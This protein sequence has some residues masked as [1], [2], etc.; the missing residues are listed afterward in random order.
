MSRYDLIVCTTAV[1]RTCLH[2]VVF[3]SYFSFLKG[4]K[5][6]WLINLDRVFNTSIKE[7]MG[8]IKEGA[9]IHC[10]EMEIEFF[11]E[12]EKLTGTR[13]SFFKAAENLILKAG[14]LNPK[15]GIL[16]LEDDWA[17]N[18]NITGKRLIDILQDIEFD[19]NDYLQLVERSRE[20][21]FNP[22]VFG[23]RLFKD[24]CIKGIQNNTSKYFLFNPERACCYPHIEVTRSVNKHT[25][26]PLFYDIGRQWQEDIAVNRTFTVLETEDRINER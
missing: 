18:P 16:W 22:G 26:I 3:P 4:V 13:E 2:R 1:D 20:V 8:Y 11:F 5:G 17:M 6:K 19:E 10:P 25:V 24:K 14:K 7:C 12:N 21:S 23:L 15:Y 9:R